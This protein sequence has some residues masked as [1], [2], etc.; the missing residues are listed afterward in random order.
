MQSEMYE[1]SYIGLCARMVTPHTPH[2]QTKVGMTLTFQ[3]QLRVYE[4]HEIHNQIVYHYKV[5]RR[6]SYGYFSSYSGSCVLM[7]TTSDHVRKNNF[8][9][10]FFI[11][12]PTLIL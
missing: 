4:L 7:V 8:A 9:H 1:S 5:I 11:S 10:N 3:F 6:K 12:I 2:Q